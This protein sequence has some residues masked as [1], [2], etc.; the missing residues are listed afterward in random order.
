MRWWSKSDDMDAAIAE[1]LQGSL[2]LKE[3]N[4]VAA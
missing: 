1:A 3:K 4:D 2:L